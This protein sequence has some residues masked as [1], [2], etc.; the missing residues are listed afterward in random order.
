MHAA[1]TSSASEFLSEL[2][3]AQAAALAAA[4]RR[5]GEVEHEAWWRAFWSRSWITIPQAEGEGEAHSGKSR[6]HLL[7]GKTI[8]REAN[9]DVANLYS[10]Y[11]LAR[12]TQ[13]IQASSTE[14]RTNPWPIKFN[15]MAFVSSLPP[16][17]GKSGP[18]YRDWGAASWWQNTRLPYGNMINVSVLGFISISLYLSLSPSISLYLFFTHTSFHLSPTLLFSYLTVA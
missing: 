5:S 6:E 4:K 10:R 2:S 15:G 18:D 14:A 11:A 9:P 13:S 7:S 12:Y 16:E 1:Q 17:T 3:A 8:R